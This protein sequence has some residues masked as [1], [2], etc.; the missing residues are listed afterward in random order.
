MVFNNVV[1]H[2]FIKLFIMVNIILSIRELILVKIH[3]CINFV[4]KIIMNIRDIRDIM[5]IISIIIII[6][7]IIIRIALIF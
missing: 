6:I 5:T 3:V 7:I 1:M 2:Y 4:W